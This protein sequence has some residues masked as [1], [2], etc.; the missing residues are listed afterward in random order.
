MLPHQGG[1]LRRH[2]DLLHRG[3]AR[4]SGVP[5][6]QPTLVVLAMP[7]P[8]PRAR[9]HGTRLQ[10]AVGQVRQQRNEAGTYLCLLAQVGRNSI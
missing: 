6:I 3:A 4:Y 1:P 2:R 8:L 7:R 9:N 5:R 10:H